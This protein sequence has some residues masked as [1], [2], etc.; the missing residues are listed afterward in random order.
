V[1][2][3]LVGLTQVNE[4]DDEEDQL[5]QEDVQ[6]GE[7]EPAIP[8]QTELLPQ[9]LTDIE[10]MNTRIDRVDQRMNR[11]ED[12]LDSMS[13]RPLIIMLLSLLFLF[14]FIFFHVEH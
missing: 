10:N 12:T 6:G 7:P 11:I 13:S 3:S 2:A 8:N 9:I 1:Y 5:A 14:I 4:E